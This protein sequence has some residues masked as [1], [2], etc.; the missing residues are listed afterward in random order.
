MQVSSDTIRSVGVMVSND[1]I[2]GVV[3]QED[4]GRLEIAYF[5]G[6]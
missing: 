6:L 5:E 1:T 3:V 2:G 4:A